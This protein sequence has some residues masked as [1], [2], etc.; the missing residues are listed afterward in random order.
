MMEHCHSIGVGELEF[1]VENPDPPPSA[2]IDLPLSK[3]VDEAEDFTMVPSFLDMVI[4]GDSSGINTLNN[5]DID[6][7]D[8]GYPGLTWAVW[9]GKMSSVTT[10]LEKKANPNISG[11]GKTF[12]PW[13]KHMLCLYHNR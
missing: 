12:T 6:M 11:N 10:L 5:E 13:M 4:S 1:R 9:A 8:K 2:R 7:K 3:L